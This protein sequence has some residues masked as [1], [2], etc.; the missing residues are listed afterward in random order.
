MSLK[1]R[2]ALITKFGAVFDLLT[3]TLKLIKISRDFEQKQKNS[4][5][6]RAGSTGLKFIIPSDDFFDTIKQ[7]NMLFLNQS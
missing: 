7:K 5:M 2:D 1:N 6:V 4:I 3:T